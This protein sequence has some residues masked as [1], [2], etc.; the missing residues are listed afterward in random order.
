MHAELRPLLTA[1]AS[2]RQLPA[3]LHACS[4]RL[5][6]L[7]ELARE[8]QALARRLPVHVAALPVGGGV[9]VTMH[10]SFFQTRAKFALALSLHS[11]DPQ[12][13]LTFS[14]RPWEGA[15]AESLATML[16]AD[17]LQRMVSDACTPHACGFGR[18]GAIVGAV[19]RGVHPQP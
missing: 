13:P 5:G 6:R 8:V 19:H 2:A 11:E 10:F 7:L 3:L 1:C 16:D 9:C 14:C 12:Q 4:L 17:V 18:L 15:P